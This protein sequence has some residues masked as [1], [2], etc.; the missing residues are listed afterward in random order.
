MSI[1]TTLNMGLG[2]GVASVDIVLNVFVSLSTWSDD[3]SCPVPCR[4]SAS[5]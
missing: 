1:Y 2:S 5:T 4:A 3:V